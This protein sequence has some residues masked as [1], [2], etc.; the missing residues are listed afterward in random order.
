MKQ[1]V[2]TAA[3]ILAVAVPV[4]WF[5]DYVVYPLILSLLADGAMFE[6]FR[7][8]NLKK[9]LVLT[10]PAYILALAAPLCAYVFLY[11]KGFRP[12]EF[13]LWFTLAFAAYLLYL[14][15]VAV[16][17]QGGSRYSDVTV[18]FTSTVYIVGAF[19]ALSVIRY[20]ENGAYLLVLVFIAAWICDVFA[21]L[22]GSLLGRHKLIPKI[23]PKKTVEGSLGGILFATVAFLLYGFLVGRFGTVS[24]KYGLLAL[25]GVLL[26][27]VSQIGDLI[28]SLIKRE[29]DVKDYGKLFPGH[30]GILD[31]FDSVL[32]VAAV[33][34]IVSIVAPPLV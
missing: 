18:I 31:R 25:F 22:V 2:I 19:T 11:L 8:V 30:G 32:A 20:M 7:A 10:I 27:V 15:L 28:A 4:L 1:R 12:Q 14:F 13:L 16:L 34:M 5:S 6:L 21:Y 26:S 33:L 9:Q 3:V 23:S 24:P 29:H 17:M